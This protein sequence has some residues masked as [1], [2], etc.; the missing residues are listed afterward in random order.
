M[1]KKSKIPTI[2]NSEEGLGKLSL[3]YT[4]KDST[5]QGNFGRGES[6]DSII[7]FK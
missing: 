1:Y 6:A 2:N 3:V 5:E 7:P 4:L